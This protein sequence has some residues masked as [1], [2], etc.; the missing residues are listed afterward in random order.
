MTLWVVPNGTIRLIPAQ[1]TNYIDTA[2]NTWLSG[3]GGGGDATCSP[4]AYPT[5]CIYANGGTWP[6]V[7][8]ITL[9]Q[10]PW[11]AGGDLRFDFIVPNGTYQIN[12]KFASNSGAN[13]LAS[14]GNFVLE[15]QGSAGTPI[16]V[17][18]LVGNN[19][20]YDFVSS[21]TVTNGQ[22]SFVIRAVNTT[23]GGVN[24]GPYISALQINQTTVGSVPPA[25][26]TNLRA[27]VH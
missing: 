15:P 5:P 4:N 26:P 14:Q 12:A 25:P 2:S 24:V 22:L 18:T 16:D 19:Q 13:P 8:D 6:T 10:A 20:P 11:Y 23:P 9:Y 7:P 21:A 3:E 27:R 17:F 1:S